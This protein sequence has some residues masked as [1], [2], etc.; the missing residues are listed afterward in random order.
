MKKYVFLFIFFSRHRVEGMRVTLVVSEPSHV[1]DDG[2]ADAT[3]NARRRIS[4]VYADNDSEKEEV[5]EAIV[6][7]VGQVGQQGGRARDRGWRRRNRQS[8]VT[9]DVS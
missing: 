2:L 7:Q 9:H 8:L 5:K 6:G 3:G 1:D 4:K